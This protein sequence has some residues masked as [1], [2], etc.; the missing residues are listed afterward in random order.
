MRFITFNQFRVAAL[1]AAGA[2]AS[3]ASTL[4]TQTYST[5][6]GPF[7]RALQASGGNG[8]YS[9]GVAPGS[10]LPPGLSLRT[11]VL[12]GVLTTPGTFHFTL[13]L[14]SGGVTDAIPI[15]FTVADVLDTSPAI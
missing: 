7:E 9:V 13:N 15:T 6:L 2:L 8:T 14:T 1:L 4:S 5:Q 10:S 11:G 3:F 12:T